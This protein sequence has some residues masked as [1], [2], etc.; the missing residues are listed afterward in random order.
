MMG[1]YSLLTP[2][3]RCSW[4]TLTQGFKGSFLGP[5]SLQSKLAAKMPFA[6]YPYLRADVVWGD[7]TNPTTYPR[8]RFDVVYDNNGKDLDTCRPLID[9]YRVRCG[10]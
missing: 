2:V 6:E 9:H 1:A 5:P 8:G 4:D 3:V 10:T 7:P